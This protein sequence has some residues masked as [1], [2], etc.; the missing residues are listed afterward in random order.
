M[1]RQE[2]NAAIEVRTQERKAAAERKPERY[3]AESECG[4]RET[5]DAT[6]RNRDSRLLRSDDQMRR[7]DQTSR[8][9]SELSS[10]LML[11]RRLDL[12]QDHYCSLI[13][14]T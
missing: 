11:V 12:T 5:A 3:S 4:D 1:R 6:T 8:H 7:S 13:E 14:M 10:S 2:R 9:E